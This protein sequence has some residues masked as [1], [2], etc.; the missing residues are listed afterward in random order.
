M[1]NVLFG[2][3]RN[4]LTEVSAT[5][6]LVP[7]LAESWDSTLDAA[8]WT[9]KI[10]QGVEFHNGKTLDSQDV[11]DSLRHH[12]TEDSKSAAKGIL[13][14]I[15]SVDADGKHAITV[16]LKSGDADF[17]FLMSDYH[18]LICPSNGDGT[19]DW[20]SGTGTGGYTLA[21][22]E[23]GIRTLTKRKSRSV[24]K[25]TPEPFRSSL[26]AS[27]TLSRRYLGAAWARG[28]SCF[29]SV[30]VMVDSPCESAR[31]PLEP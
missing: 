30:I 5:G 21:E 11:V 31:T 26:G 24:K 18:L 25:Q 23:P 20:Q 1:I 12:L 4:N 27:V 8:K 19:I 6:E 28:G 9:F 17:P 7:E 2:Q 15:E 10:R 16:T 29:T 13:G 14:G 22:H 3:V